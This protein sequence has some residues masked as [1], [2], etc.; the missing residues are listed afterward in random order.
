MLQAKDATIQAQQFTIT[1]QQH[2]LSGEV[3]IE[4]L[5]DITPQPGEDKEELLG[6]TLAITKYEGKGFEL[7]LPE[8][9]RRLK[10]LFADEE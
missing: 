9:F 2:L 4:S 6:G 3:I 1:N 8:I 10:K 5:R 7:N